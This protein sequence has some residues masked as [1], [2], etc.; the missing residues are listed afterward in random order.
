MAALAR[1][2][3]GPGPLPAI[4]VATTAP[5][6]DGVARQAEQAV[7]EGAEVIELRADLLRGT[8]AAQDGADTAGTAVERAR[9]AV[10]VLRSARRASGSAPL[11]LT[12]RSGLE[13]GALDGGEASY[14]AALDALLGALADV[15][16]TER[17]DALD[18]E[19][20]RPDAPAL[21]RRAHELGLDAVAS[22]HD[23][24]A[25]PSDADLHGRLAAMETAGA[26]VLKIA[27]TPCD[28]VDVARLLRVTAEAS[29]ALSAPVI[30]MSMG[31]LGIVTRV[32]GAVFGSALTFAT[33]GDRPSAPGQPPI[34]LVRSARELL[35]PDLR[36]TS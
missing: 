21:I 16:A 33:A 30:T 32:A 15:A 7:R 28:A 34:A 19:I 31:D 5:D 25:T 2:L 18:V 23:F 10:E 27:V 14:A 24:H 26:D 17:P 1:L 8:P 3:D 20:A 29:A 13:G 6:A 11:L 4:A 36:A 9:R 12:I 35:G 22:F